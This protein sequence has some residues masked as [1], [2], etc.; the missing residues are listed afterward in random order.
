[1]NISS[2]RRGFTLVELLIVMGIIVLAAAIL[3]PV[4]LSLSERN[5]VPKGASM[6]ENA[7]QM[8][9]SRTL[10][11][12]LPAGIRLIQVPANRRSIVSGPG[13]AWYN[14]IQFIQQPGDY[15]EAWLWGFSN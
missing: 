11:E 12:K 7:L 1:M 5:Q 6:I 14:E 4:T 15:V 10:A 8:A 9:K 13:F 3:V 2:T